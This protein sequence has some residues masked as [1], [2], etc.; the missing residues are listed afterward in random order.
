M[1]WIGTGLIISAMVLALLTAAAYYLVTHGRLSWLRWGRAGVWLTLGVAV[2]SAGLLLALFLLQ[3][4]DVAYVYNYSSRDLGLRFRIAA[5]WAGQP[6]SLVVWALAGLL[7]TPLLIKRTRH[8]EPYVLCLLMLL[9]ALLFL[10]ILIRNPF[11]PT[12][13]DGVATLPP[14]GRGLN[15]QL[16]NV[17]MV[18]HPPTLFTS[19]AIL[20]IPFAFALAGLWRRDYDGWVRLALPWLLAGWG[21]LG[22]ALAMGGYWAYES[23]GW[24]GYWAWDPVENSSLV[25]WITSAALVHG[26]ILQKAHGGLRRTNFVLA[27]VTYALVFFASFLTRSGVLSNFSVHSFTEAGLKQIMIGSLVGL[28]VLGAAF[29]MARWRDIP[30]RPLSGSLLSRDAMFMLLILGMGVIAAVIGVATSMPWISS[31]KSIGYMLQ[32]A[33]GR[34]FDLSDGSN[35]GNIPLA[36]GRFSLTASFFERTVPPL[37]L[38]M[39]LLVSVTPLFGWRTTSRVKLL[40]TLRWP[41]GVALLATL[42]I[43]LLGVMKPLAL[44]YSALA[45][46][47]IATNFLL[48]IRTLRSGWLQIGGYLAHVGFGLLLIGIVGSYVYSSEEIRMVIPQG[49]TQRVFG[50]SFTFWGYDDS[51]ADGRNSLRL[52]IDGETHASVAQPELFY[53]SRM[54]AWTRT[55]AIKRSLWEDLYISPED[56]VPPNDPNTATLTPNQEAQIGP[57]MLRLEGFSVTDQLATDSTAVVGAVVRVTQGAD[58]RTV[59]P[60][61]RLTVGKPIVE[62]PVP[63]SGG[64]QLVLSNFVPGTQE[65]LFRID[66]LNLPV[67]PARAIL[68]VSLKPAIALV[69]LGALLMALGCGLAHVR[70]RLEVSLGRERI[71]RRRL[72]D[73]FGSRRRHMGALHGQALPGATYR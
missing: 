30:V 34:V 69:W 32:T 27:I 48:I 71:P 17:W 1:Y 20:G 57:Y 59:R 63:L 65:V 51:H 52:E 73:L 72:R 28:L 22:L 9:Q 61:V 66:G 56:Y 42:V 13:I 39:L 68:E 14:D 55:P 67:E 10:F 36:D 19:Y 33:L 18:I 4:Y 16:H 45:S 46:F 31:V 29:T 62:L 58:V 54:G 50:H 49:E 6:G 7:I 12:I 47:A 40:R 25:P 64:R 8:F 26:L 24:G 38:V 3:R 41:A 53:N 43:M 21:I 15:P 11:A 70:R 2:A 44:A 5:T 37:V 35:Y 60:H 23:L